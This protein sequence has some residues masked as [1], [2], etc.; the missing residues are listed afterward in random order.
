MPW[1]GVTCG[2][3]WQDLHVEMTLDDMHV[4]VMLDDFRL[5][6]YDFTQTPAGART[7]KHQLSAAVS[8]FSD[9]SQPPASRRSSS[10]SHDLQLPRL[11]SPRS[12]RRSV[13]RPPPPPL[14]LPSTWCAARAHRQHR[15]LPLSL[16]I[17]PHQNDETGIQLPRGLVQ[18]RQ[19]S[20]WS[21]SA[22]PGAAEVGVVTHMACAGP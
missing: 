3:R 12:R 15:V 7:S 2:K 20:E 22:K 9:C 10:S 8:P 14:R 21:R 16:K 4:E 6:D 13:V 18:I 5:D 17:W 11:P 1:Q 19:L